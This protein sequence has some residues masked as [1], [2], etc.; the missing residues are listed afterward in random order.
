MLLKSQAQDI[1]KSALNHSDADQTE[2]VLIAKQTWLTR[3]AESAINQNL[4]FEDTTLVITA[5]NDKRIGVTTTNDLSPAGIKETTRLANEIS[6][7]QKPDEKFVSFPDKEMAP[8]VEKTVEVNPNLN[9]SPDDM[10]K[11]V[12][13]VAAQAA[14]ENLKASGAFR[15]DIETV[16]VSNSLGVEQFGS[17]GKS[18]LSLTMV[19]D[20]EQSGYA[21]G[22]DPD[23][24]QIDI[25]TVAR[26]AITKAKRNINPVSLPDGQ[27]TVILEPA[28]VGQL[29]LFLGFLGF[30]GRTMM[31][32]RS[33][34][35]GKTGE[36]I[37]GKN[38]SITDEPNNPAFGSLLFDYEGIA[39]KNITPIDGGKAG[40]GAYDSYYAN[41]MKIAPTGHA[42]PPNNS[43]GPYPK[44][45]VMAP[46]DK[47]TAEMIASV[48]RGVLITHFWYINFLNP[49]KTMITGTI[50]DGTFLIENGQVG[51]AIKN[52]R[53]NQS[54][55]E[56]FSNAEM[57]STERIVYP[58]YSSLMLV[59]AMKVNDFNLVQETKEAWEGKC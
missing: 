6:R 43:Y 1:L 7:L 49:M 25:R 38:I 22:Y 52:M 39:R 55:L 3:F 15:H 16:A 13:K 23:P 44:N 29:L 40:Q 48:E 37:T 35:S 46:G 30:G 14:T 50:F 2:V 58:Q 57:L 12:K 4:N 32:H 28:A 8:P 20:G 47:T 17:F 5:V 9:F 45:L 59:P 18:E 36:L 11:A 33:F 26:R 51:P 42:L 53:T 56:A 34:M 27:Y 19:G 21:I 10:G 31:Q 54:I 41:L 24:R